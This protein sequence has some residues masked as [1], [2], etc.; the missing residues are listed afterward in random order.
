LLSKKSLGLDAI[1]FRILTIVSWL[2]FLNVLGRF[3]YL[4]IVSLLGFWRGNRKSERV[5]DFHSGLSLFRAE[6]MQKTGQLCEIASFSNV[7]FYA[8]FILTDEP[9]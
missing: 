7:L 2:R 1:H 5:V 3:F 9:N 8:Y 6:R 4:K